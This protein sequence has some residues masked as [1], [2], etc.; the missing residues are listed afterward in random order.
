MLRFILTYTILF[1]VLNYSYCQFKLNLKEG[2]FDK[3]GNSIV[4][5]TNGDVVNES[6]Y[7]FIES[8]IR[9]SIKHQFSNKILTA[10]GDER[11]PHDSYYTPWRTNQEHKFSFRSEGIPLIYSEYSVD[12]I[13]LSIFLSASDPLDYTYNKVIKTSNLIPQ[14]NEFIERLNDPSFIFKNDDYELDAVIEQPTEVKDPVLF[15]KKSTREENSIPSGDK[16]LEAK[17]IYGNKEVVSPE[18]LSGWEWVSVPK[19]NDK[20][21]ES[22]FIEFEIVINDKGEI[23]NT[24]IIDKNVSDQLA[25]LYQQAVKKCTFRYNKDS[26][27]PKI[28]KGMITFKIK[29]R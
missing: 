20:S 24:T 3:Q 17:P 27:P 6:K 4:Y 1:L 29:N 7:S 28:T 2:Y 23:V 9:I 15:K 11:F 14:W 16:V 22:G 5:V 12:K 8:S 25:K 18:G 13:V 10:Q 26:T 19:P 21:N